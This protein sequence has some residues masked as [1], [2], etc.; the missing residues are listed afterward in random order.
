MWDAT[1]QPRRFAFGRGPLPEGCDLELVSGPLEDELT[2]LASQ[3][4]QSL[5]LEGGPTIAGRF[6]AAD[7]IDKLAIFVAPKLVGG[8][9][10][11]PLFA[12]AGA[13]HM[14][15][16]RLVR[17]MEIQKIGADLLLIGYLHEP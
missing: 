8:D 9:D 13:S 5:L 3:G 17:G 15:D 4:V 2:R 12:G 14:E 6:L 7:V 11:P 10:A 16:V 1:R